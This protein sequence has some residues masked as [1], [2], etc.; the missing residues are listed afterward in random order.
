M[1]LVV[2]RVT[3]ASVRAGDELLGEIG[4][5]AVVLAGIGPDDDRAIVDRMADK[6]LGLRYFADAEG[7]TNLAIADVGGS[8]LVVSQFTLY[9]DVSR[10][11]RPG[12]PAR[13]LPEQAVPLVDRFVERLRDAG[14][15]GRDGAVRGGDGGRARQRRPVHARPRLGARPRLRDEPSRTLAEKYATAGTD[16]RVAPGVR[17]LH[18]GRPRTLRLPRPRI[19][20]FLMAT[21]GIGGSVRRAAALALALLVTLAIAAPALAKSGGNAAAAAACQERWLP[22]WTDSAGNAFRNSG[23]CVS[24]AAHGGTLTPSW[25]T[26]SIRSPSS[27]RISG[28]DGFLATV[29]GSGLEP[30]SSVDLLLTWGGD[31]LSIGD[32]A[33]RERQCRVHGQRQLHEPRVAAD[34]RLRRRHARRRRTHGVSVPLPDASICPPAHLS[35]ISESW[36]C[37]RPRRWRGRIGPKRAGSDLLGGPAAAAAGLHLR[38]LAVADEGHRLQVGQP[39]AQGALSVHA[40]R[41]GVPAGDRALAADVADAGHGRRGLQSRKCRRRAPE[42][43]EIVAR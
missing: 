35:R 38:D 33:G 20:G 18:A 24:Y 23:A 39:S 19:E 21:I 36:R 11:R 2:Q 40:D 32:V 22:R 26:R 16:D 30:D 9:A 13:R 1:R 8:F 42:R 14:A 12:S 41:L 28:T 27:Y 29:T 43:V 25:S 6:L 4:S 5:G 3:R 31:P 17:R 37:R 15:A 10:G 7:R 34:R